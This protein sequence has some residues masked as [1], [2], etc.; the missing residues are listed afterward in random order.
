MKELSSEVVGAAGAAGVDPEPAGDLPG[1][2]DSGGEGAAGAAGE[3][4]ADIDPGRARPGGVKRGDGCGGTRF[5]VFRCAGDHAVVVDSHGVAVVA[6]R[7]GQYSQVGDVVRAGRGR[8]GHRGRQQQNAKNHGAAM[9]HESFSLSVS[10]EPSNHCK[11]ETFVPCT[12]ADCGGAKAD[13]PGVARQP[14]RIFRAAAKA[15]SLA[16][17]PAA[18]RPSGDPRSVPRPG[19]GASGFQPGYFRFLQA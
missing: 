13:E 12:C 1:V 18:R 3:A 9:E 19:R 16:R 5:A 4:A 8:P 17:P 10:R 6:G 14:V 15:A 11:L 2:V 7:A